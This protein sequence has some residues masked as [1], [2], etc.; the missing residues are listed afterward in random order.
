M[1]ASSTV[2]FNS[3]QGFLVWC[4]QQNRRRPAGGRKILAHGERS[5]PWESGLSGIS[6]APA[7]RQIV[8]VAGTR[9]QGRSLLHKEWATRLRQHSSSV[10]P[11]ALPRFQCSTFP[12]LVS[13]ADF[14]LGHNLAALPGLL[15]EPV[16]SAQLYPERVINDTFHST[17]VVAVLCGPAPLREKGR[18]RTVCSLHRTC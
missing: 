11:P 16:C 17:F 12:G 15:W 4:G 5:E 6:G 7:G 13:F 1:L 3:T 14:S 10:S 18:C 9:A 8:V 2:N